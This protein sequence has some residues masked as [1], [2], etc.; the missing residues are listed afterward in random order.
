MYKV[1]LEYWSYDVKEK[2]W[3]ADT[4][5]NWAGTKEA[6]HAFG[7]KER[8][9]EIRKRWVKTTETGSVPFVEPLKVTASG[10]VKA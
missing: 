1:W 4:Q 6:A 8:A 7:S 10:V 5:G 2:V 9:D 3:L